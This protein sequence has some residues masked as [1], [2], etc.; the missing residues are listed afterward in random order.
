MA[1]AQPTAATA[2][3]ARRTAIVAEAHLVAVRMAEVAHHMVVEA[4]IAVEETHEA[5]RV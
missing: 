5:D 3:V 4:L 2:V 1:E